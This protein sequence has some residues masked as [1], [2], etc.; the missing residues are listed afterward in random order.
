MANFRPGVRPKPRSFKR[1]AV[2]AASSGLED[3]NVEISR[4]WPGFRCRQS[5]RGLNVEAASFRP[6]RPLGYERISGCWGPLR[7]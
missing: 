4:F 6:P 5:S 3:L 1:R 7:I 2:P